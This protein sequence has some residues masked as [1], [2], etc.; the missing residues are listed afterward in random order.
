MS[1]EAAGATSWDR[2]RDGGLRVAD[3]TVRI[4]D[5]PVVDAATF[6]APPGALTALVGPNGAGKS[7]LLRAVAGADRPAAGTMRLDGAD[8][9][10]LGRRE[11]ARRV[12]FVEQDAGTELPLSVEAVVGL[13]RTPY[14]ALLGGPDRESADAVDA[15]IASAGIEH[16]RG[17]EITRLSGGERQRVLLARALAQHPRL[18]LLDEPT[19]H[20][21]IAAQLAALTLLRRLTGEGVTVLAALHD[22]GLAAA[23]ADDVVVLHAGRVVAEGAPLATLTPELLVEVYRVRA[24]WLSDPATGRPVLA[25]SP[26]A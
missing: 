24:S 4:G 9:G 11:R 7:S 19:N 8:L 20:L 2:S 5:R 12:A 21:D 26:L 1:A 23:W 13:G 14:G 25:A 3:L 16:L 22:L 6:S 15:A 17:R 18:L 10:A